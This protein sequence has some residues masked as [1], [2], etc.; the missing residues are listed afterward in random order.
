MRSRGSSENSPLIA[1]HRRCRNPSVHPARRTPHRPP[2]SPPSAFGPTS[3]TSGLPSPL[4]PRLGPHRTL[5][6]VFTVQ[7]RPERSSLLPLGAHF[8]YLTRL[9]TSPSVFPLPP[10]PRLGLLR[11][12]T[13]ANT[14]QSRPQ[15]ISRLTLGAHFAQFAPRQHARLIRQDATHRIHKPH[16]CT[17]LP[18]DNELSTGSGRHHPANPVPSYGTNRVASSHAA[19]AN[20]RRPRIYLRPSLCRR[21]RPQPTACIR[22]MCAILGR[23]CSRQYLGSA[24]PHPRSRAIP[25]KP[26]GT[27]QH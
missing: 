23:P 26:P 4:L 17:A 10:Q 16:P 12:L 13:D 24:R 25:L 19:T 9:P 2:L 3:H 21:C 5:A 15:R 11:T 14:V 8:A 1:D 27:R 18:V 7:S 6:V 22:P 20:T